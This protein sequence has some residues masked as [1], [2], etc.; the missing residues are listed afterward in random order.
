V[1]FF[2]ATFY[3]LAF[4]GT[5]VMKVKRGA[6]YPYGFKEAV[7][8]VYEHTLSKRKTARI[9]K[10]S[11]HTV[12]N[13]LLGE[14]GERR[15]RPRKTSQE[16]DARIQQIIKDNPESYIDEIVERLWAQKL[17]WMPRT[18]MWRTLVRLNFT[19]KRFVKNA[20]ERFTPENIE[21]RAEYLAEFSLYDL[22]QTF[23]VDETGVHLQ[24]L[25]RYT[26]KLHA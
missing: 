17:V 24:L 1:C 19:R 8:V 16:L 18:S 4:G 11:R 26:H 14:K 15:G 6:A 10:I 7:K 2:I 20:A 21:R 9:M 5:W 13:A 25:E 23:F 22:S 3:L 12:T